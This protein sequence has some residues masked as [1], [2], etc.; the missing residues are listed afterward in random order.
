MAA[1]VH[2]VAV[3]IAD[4]GSSLDGGGQAT[5]ITGATGGN[6]FPSATPDQ[7]SDAILSGL[8]AVQ[9]TVAMQSDCSTA[10]AN[11]VT[12]SFSPASVPAE[13][14]GVANF[15]ET[16]AVTANAAQQGHTYSCR[17]I[18][19]IDDNSMTDA[20]GAVIYET[21]TITAKD[22]TAPTASCAPT[23]NPSGKNVPTAGNGAGN[24]GQ[25]PDGFYAL[26]ASDNV[27][28]TSIVVKDGGSSFVS[29][30]FASGDKVKIVQAPG[31]TPTDKRPGPGVIV[32][33]LTLKGDAVLTVTDATGNVTTVHCNVPPPPK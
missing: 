21:K 10:T 22:T 26:T 7:V 28:V 23:T 32:S 19:L 6:Y 25:N 13:S 30:A 11:V 1:N 14:G 5:A 12:T 4:G 17:D 18:A 9:V 2:V 29:N 20:T 16:I 3:N 24:S 33:Q 8:S 27:A 31:A 15:V